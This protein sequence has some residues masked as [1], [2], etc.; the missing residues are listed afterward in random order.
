VGT[1][2]L[3]AWTT[4]LL[5]AAWAVPG[6][7]ATL[8]LVPLWALWLRRKIG[9]ISGDGHGAGIELVETGLLLACLL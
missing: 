1:P 7:L 4:L 8:A 6:L 2:H 5:A 3:V 9:G